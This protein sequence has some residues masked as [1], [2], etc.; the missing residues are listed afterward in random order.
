MN[1]SSIKRYAA[2]FPVVIGMSYLFFVFTNSSKVP[3]RITLTTPYLQLMVEINPHPS[4]HNL[5]FLQDTAEVLV[6]FDQK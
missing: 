2:L 3:I 1:I 5:N 6:A 4:P